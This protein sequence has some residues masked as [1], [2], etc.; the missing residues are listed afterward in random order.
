MRIT[1]LRY[2]G[3]LPFSIFENYSEIFDFGDGLQGRERTTGK[4]SGKED[5]KDL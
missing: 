2:I 4:A 3:T 5:G 1:S